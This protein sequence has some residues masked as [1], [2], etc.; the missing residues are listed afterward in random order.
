MI[1]FKK[2]FTATGNIK[3]VGP[4]SLMKCGNCKFWASGSVGDFGICQHGFYV[5]TFFDRCFH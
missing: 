5:D 2:G 4:R 1:E 3:I